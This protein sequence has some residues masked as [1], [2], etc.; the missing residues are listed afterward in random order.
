[1][2]KNFSFPSPAAPAANDSPLPSPT[3]LAPTPA[4]RPCRQPLSLQP[5]SEPLTPPLSP[6]HSP[7]VSPID[8]DSCCT[9]FNS[10]HDDT[11]TA[12]LASFALT[13]SKAKSRYASP[14]TSDVEC[15]PFEDV[16]RKRQSMALMQT[17]DDLLRQLGE[18]VKRV[19]PASG[20]SRKG[21]TGSLTETNGVVKKRSCNGKS[22]SSRSKPAK[23]RETNNGSGRRVAV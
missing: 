13:T 19:S 6:M 12:T 21:S 4:P 1:M 20:G 2:F 23:S 10:A 16:R 14:E 17:N 22:R 3:K 8:S 11:L 9:Y 5:S 18:L 15:D 7:S